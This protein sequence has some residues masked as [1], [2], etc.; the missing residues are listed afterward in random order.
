[1]LPLT[2]LPSLIFLLGGIGAWEKKEL[3][4]KSYTLQDIADITARHGPRQ[5]VTQCMWVSTVNK[6]N[7]K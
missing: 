2:M 3:K 1:M 7:Y 5:T 4:K 6:K